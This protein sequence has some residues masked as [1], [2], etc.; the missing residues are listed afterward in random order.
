MKAISALFL[1]ETSAAYPTSRLAVHSTH[2]S[3]PLAPP[4]PQK[5]S[6]PIIHENFI[7]NNT[8]TNNIVIPVFRVDG[9]LVVQRL[10]VLHV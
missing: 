9:L 6:N 8:F 4:R 1:Y 7:D 5:E 3:T 2:V 10:I